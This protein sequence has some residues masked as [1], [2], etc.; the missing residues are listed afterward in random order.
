MGKRHGWVI[1]A[2]VLILVG[3]SFLRI[4]DL[5]KENIWMDEG[6]TLETAG[7]ESIGD[8]VDNTY[9]LEINP[10]LYYGFMHYWIKL[11]SSEFFLRLPS[12]IFGIISVFL[13][14]VLARKIYNEKAGLA[15]ALIMAVSLINVLYSQEMR[16]YTWF[17]MLVLG[18]SIYFVNIL[19][20]GRTSDYVLYIV[21]TTI[22]LYSHYFATYI[23]L[24]QN[25]IVFLFF[26]FKKKLLAKW[27]MSQAIIA[28]TFAFWLGK[29]AQQMIYW[30][31]TWKSS[32]MERAMIPPPLAKMGAM[33]FGI[34]LAI[35]LIALVLLAILVYVK[36]IRLSEYLRKLKFNSVL[37]TGFFV[38]FV[39]FSYFVM[40]RFISPHFATKYTVF[41]YPILYL[42]MGNWIVKMKK[43]AWVFIA[44]LLVVSLINLLT[45]YNET[46]KEEW[47]KTAQFIGMSAEQGDL[48]LYCDERINYAFE[49]YYKGDVEGISVRS[50]ALRQ[51]NQDFYDSAKEMIDAAESKFLI[52]S[53]CG[54]T[55]GFYQETLGRNFELTGRQVFNGVEVYQYS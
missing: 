45:Y 53:H 46:T 22:S 6:F 3:A 2:L 28:L 10:P 20:R 47:D 38:L 48:L 42:L 27:I 54:K 36:R 8:V 32:M 24:L 30:A 52:A 9:I 37:F 12:A 19:K 39:L 23:I 26:V 7:R 16:V 55:N 44:V 43:F 15:A 40:P 13:M 33:I 29:F 5:G 31:E 51:E 49:Y 21:I 1:L 4:Y 18:S 25:M 50:S 11:G 41:F 17:V 35:G 14:F 34:P